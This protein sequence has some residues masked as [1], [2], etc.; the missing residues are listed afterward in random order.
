MKM[1]TKTHLQILLSGV[2]LSALPLSAATTLWDTSFAGTTLDDSWLVNVTGDSTITQNNGLEILPDGIGGFD[3]GF[4]ATNNVQAGTNPG[5]TPGF[6][7]QFNGNAAYNF[8]NHDLQLTYDN[9]SIPTDTTS[10]L[11]IFHS[12]VTGNA[13]TNNKSVRNSSPGAYLR[14]RSDFK[15]EVLDYIGGS[16]VASGSKTLTAMPASIVFDL[17][18][19]GW[20][21]DITGTTFTDTSTTT[22]GTWA[23]ISAAT[24]ATDATLVLGTYQEGNSAWTSGDPITLGG[25]EAVAIPEPS[26][27]ALLGLAGFG[28]A[29][30]RRR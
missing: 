8:F 21:V 3:R 5:F 4:L 1:K 9:L 28:F 16:R 27:T 22:S 29:L 7:A 13:V 25:F 10:G 23:N 11:L 15:L 18:A 17:N 6:K 20:S 30:R 14:V 12:G 24:F 26:S 19:T 2:A